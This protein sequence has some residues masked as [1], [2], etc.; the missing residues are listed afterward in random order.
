MVVK[1]R[2]GATTKAKVV[3]NRIAIHL[4]G[5]NY[6]ESAVGEDVSDVHGEPRVNGAVR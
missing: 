3:G 4:G 2:T 6:E 1:K 5:A